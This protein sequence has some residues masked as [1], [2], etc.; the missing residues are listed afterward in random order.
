MENPQEPK[1]PEEVVEAKKDIFFNLKYMGYFLAGRDAARTD[2]DMD[3]VV[4]KAKFYIC[5]QRNILMEDPVW[6]KYHR[7]EQI[8]IEYYALL[9]NREPEALKTFEAQLEGLYGDDED[10]LDKQIDQNRSTIE[11][12]K[13]RKPETDEDLDFDPAKE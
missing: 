8:L 3:D 7:N 1:K 12:L 13:K 6:E 4:R 9:F 2:V 10:W 11:E 5:E